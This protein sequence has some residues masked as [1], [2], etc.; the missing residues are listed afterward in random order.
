[1][2]ISKEKTSTRFVALNLINCK[3]IK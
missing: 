1:M 2:G 3:K